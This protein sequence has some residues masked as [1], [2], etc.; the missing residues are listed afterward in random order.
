M[1]QSWFYLT[2]WRGPPP[3]FTNTVYSAINTTIVTAG[4]VPTAD[5]SEVAVETAIRIPARIS[6]ADR[7]A[8]D[9]IT[10]TEVLWSVGRKND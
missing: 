8:S 4:N 6:D 9:I 1:A 5:T 7:A 10:S 2:L 3:E